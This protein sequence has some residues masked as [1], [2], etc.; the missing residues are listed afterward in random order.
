MR[1]NPSRQRRLRTRS[2]ALLA[3]PVLL[4]FGWLVYQIPAVQARLSWRV[5]LAR[6]Y[7]G[8]VI[9]PA[10]PVPTPLPTQT[11]RA[12]NQ[13]APTAA[14]LQPTPS[15][16]AQATQANQPTATA[17][18]TPTAIPEVVQLA[19]PGFVM[20]E[21]NNC[22]PASLAMYLDY[23]GWEGTQN[24][25]SDLIKP[26]AEDRNVNVEE[27]V[28]YVRTRAGWLNAEYRVGGDIDLLKQ[29]I[30]AGIPVMIEESFYFTEP[31]WPNDDLWAAHYL[32]LT[33]YDD[34]RRVFS[35]QDSFHGPDQL[36]EY[37]ALDKEWQIFN[38]VYI[39]VYP[40]NRQ[41]TIQSILG[42][43]WNVDANRQK[44]LE[45]ARTE[46]QLDAENP[47]PWFNLGSNL[48]YFGRYEEA[49]AAYDQSRNLGLPQRMLRYQFGPFFAYFHA[50]RT[51]D[52]LALTEYALQ[53]TPNAEEALLWNG[54]A[55]YRKGDT[56]RAVA[57][58]RKA[59][60]ANPYYLD[61]R[62]ALDFV[63]ASP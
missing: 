52:L 31:F 19:S 3:L 11:A 32:L 2:L 51:D 53:R 1:Y 30:A 34:T 18:P 33:G 28:Y 45:I 41:T 24:T 15:A 36:V 49:A 23:Y 12:L 39:L 58:F 61:A 29:L 43:D 4:V 60:E 10:G 50:G 47:Y 44:A 21:I 48:V 13:A 38:R 22:G 62:Y 20:Q 57:Q 40:P 27:L 59:L 16:T 6:A 46:T 7:I 42:S 5:E 9:H 37:Q 25:I 14:V 26:V 17:L 63:G 8:G 35:A 55:L 56:N 54:W